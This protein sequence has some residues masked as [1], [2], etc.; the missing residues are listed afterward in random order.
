MTG[1]EERELV[2]MQR[3]YFARYGQQLWLC[4]WVESARLCAYQRLVVAAATHPLLH[5][6]IAGV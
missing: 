5:T 3:Q 4:E 6:S 2:Q 1:P